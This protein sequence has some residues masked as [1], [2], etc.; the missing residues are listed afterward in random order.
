MVIEKKINFAK[1]NNNNRILLVDPEFDLNLAPSCTLLLKISKDSFSYAVINN[2]SKTIQALYDQPEC[3]DIITD[4]I[5]SLQNDPY[6][7][8]NFSKVKFSLF[9]YDTLSI[10]GELYSES[11]YE[12]YADLINSSTKNLHIQSSQPEG[13]RS[14]FSVDKILENRITDQFNSATI[15]DHSLSLRHSI[16]KLEETLLVLNVG[17]SSFEV[18]YRKANKIVFN[19]MLDK[20][21]IEEFNYFILLIVRQLKIDTQTNVYLSGIINMDD[22]AYCCIRKYFNNI[23]FL[24]PMIDISSNI[25]LNELPLHYYTNLLALNLCE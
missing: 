4:S 17:V 9:S 15:Y 5:F 8:L 22:S 2:E 3:E 23:H 14:F 13:I 6:L 12:F 19:N 25:I 16:N 7:R 24:T 21:N 1:M 10:P 18:I 11:D 20:A